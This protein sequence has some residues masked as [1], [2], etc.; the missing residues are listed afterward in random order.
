MPPMES[1]VG[2]GVL[3]PDPNSRFKDEF[4]DGSACHR[5]SCVTAAV[6]LH[7]DACRS[8]GCE[9]KL[10][11]DVVLVG[12]SSS[13]PAIPTVLPNW[14]MIEPSMSQP[15]TLNMAIVPVAAIP[16]L[17]TP[18]AGGVAQPPSVDTASGPAPEFTLG[19]VV[20]LFEFAA[21]AWVVVTN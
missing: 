21:P 6:P 16:I 18:P 14:V 4:A 1:P 2:V 3:P 13:S 9:L 19:I 17:P 7:H 8:S 10:E 11:P 5:K 15:S 20:P 12:G